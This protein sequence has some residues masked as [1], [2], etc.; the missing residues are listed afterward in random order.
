MGKKQSQLEMTVTSIQQRYGALAL[1]KG[2]PPLVGTAA[3]VP[4]IPTSF[5]ELDKA[6]GI[7]GLARGRVSEI[8][9]PAT[10][11]KTTLALKFLA[12]AQVNEGQVG[13][14]DYAHAFDPDYAYR[15]GLD[16][17]RLLIATPYDLTEA[18]VTTEALATSGALSALVFDAPDTL[19]SDN[20]DSTLLAACLDRIVAPLARAGT[21]LLFLRAPVARVAPGLSALAHHATVRLYITRERWLRPAVTWAGLRTT[22]AMAAVSPQATAT[23]SPQATAG[24]SASLRGQHNDIHGYEGRVEI[25]KNR[26]GPAGRIVTIAIRFNGTVRGEGL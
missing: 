26:L 15:C 21:V 23:V 19:C 5:A 16:L 13:Y 25:I 17:S 9:G 22:Q 6:L 1:A 4:H 11:G 14:I 8:L 18:L 12:Q 2:R 3:R 7:G 20:M 10:S 24:R